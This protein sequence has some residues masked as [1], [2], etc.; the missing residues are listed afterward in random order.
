[1]ETSRPTCEEYNVQ[2]RAVVHNEALYPTERV[3]KK[4]I[5]K[6]YTE[7]CSEHCGGSHIAITNIVVAAL[8]NILPP[9][10]KP[11]LATNKIVCTEERN[12]KSTLFLYRQ[13]VKFVEEYVC[14]NAYESGPSLPCCVKQGQRATSSTC[15][16][17]L[18]R[19]SVQL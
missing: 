18:L 16:N 7:H 2:Q 10:I 9:K 11:K 1:M 13:L 6:I 12:I 4:G 17:C 14:G 8:T 15:N 5:P 19:T 3:N